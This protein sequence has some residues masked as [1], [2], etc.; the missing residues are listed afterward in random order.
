MAKKE[1]S[2]IPLSELKEGEMYVADYITV[3]NPIF[4]VLK[5]NNGDYHLEIYNGEIDDLWI[6]RKFK[7][8]WYT[9]TG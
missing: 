9:G 2:Q 3:I 4:A 5:I 8:D 1:E 7:G 6:A